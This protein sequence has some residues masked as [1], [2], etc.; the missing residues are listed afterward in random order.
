MK[1]CNRCGKEK[2]LE[3]FGKNKTYKD[4]YTNRCKECMNEVTRDNR[5]KE[6]PECSVGSCDKASR[7]KGLCPGHYTRLRL[8][9]DVQE[10]KPLQ[11]RS[12][13]GD[14]QINHDGYRI[15]KRPGHPNA[16]AN[17]SI[18]EHVIIMSEALGRPLIKG[19]NVHHKNGDRLDN[20]IENLELW[21]KVQPAGQRVEDKVAWAIDLL[22]TY[23]P[24]LLCSLENFDLINWKPVN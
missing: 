13:N 3:A 12:A 15:V 16:R 18:F 4:G 24:E 22:Q 1:P 19:E 8:Y 9:G 11:S 21:S 5:K 7:H 20:R 2:P 23:R 6:T 14:G 17:G 10:D